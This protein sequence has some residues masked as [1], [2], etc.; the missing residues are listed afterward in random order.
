M[1]KAV[2]PDLE[3]E[4]AE[5]MNPNRNQIS[6]SNVENAIKISKTATSI[7]KMKQLR[8]KL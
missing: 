8:A 2:D 3:D 1:E 7:L 4:D 5:N 6:Y